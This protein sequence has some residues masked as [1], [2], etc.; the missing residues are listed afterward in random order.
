MASIPVAD[1]SGQPATTDNIFADKRFNLVVGALGGAGS[2][3]GL[4]E[5]LQDN[6]FVAIA[7]FALLASILLFIVAVLGPESKLRLVATF[8]A[9]LLCSAVLAGSVAIF[10]GPAK[11]A[12]DITATPLIDAKP[13]T[14]GGVDI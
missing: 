12:M 14:F 6:P 1:P 3:L 5:L 4:K 11:V 9:V 8:A 10:V 7:V 13:I 2:A